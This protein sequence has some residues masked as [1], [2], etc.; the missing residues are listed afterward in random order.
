MPHAAACVYAEA[1][2]LLTATED[3]NSLLMETDASPP[4]AAPQ[5]LADSQDV[6][7]CSDDHMVSKNLAVL[8]ADE[9]AHPA[10]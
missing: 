7:R 2:A 1:L 5:R 3:P 8:T 6:T 10:P 4:Q 9:A